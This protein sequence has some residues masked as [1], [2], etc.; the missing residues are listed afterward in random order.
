MAAVAAVS[1]AAAPARC[2][3]TRQARSAACPALQHGNAR[4]CSRSRR[5]LAG[6]A[7]AAG[8]ARVQRRLGLRLR[9]QA[10]GNGAPEVE[11]MVI[12][13]SGPAGYTAAIYAARA[14]LRPFVFE[15]LSAGGQRGVGPLLH[16]ARLHPV[17]CGVC[18]RRSRLPS[19]SAAPARLPF[20][21]QAA[22]AAAS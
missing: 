9:A 20:P 2:A 15:G 22:C 7:A 11:N 1:V 17:G 18:C 14:N 12:I 8:P 16:D 13:G 21:P 19:D 10:S 6:T 3:A 5:S 4:S